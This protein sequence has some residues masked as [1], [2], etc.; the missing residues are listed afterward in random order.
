MFM[1]VIKFNRE[2]VVEW[3]NDTAKLFK[4][5]L[6]AYDKIDFINAQLIRQS[7]GYVIIDI[8]K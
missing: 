6:D 3:G 5:I 2:T 7:D 1:M 4:L 8:N